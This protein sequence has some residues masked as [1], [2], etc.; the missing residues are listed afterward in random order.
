MFMSKVNDER[1]ATMMED[2]RK[3]VPEAELP[4]DMFPYLWN[5]YVIQ[6]AQKALAR[7]QRSTL[8]QL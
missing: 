7:E 2:L 5:D 1:R 3:F 4:P 6:D 8:A